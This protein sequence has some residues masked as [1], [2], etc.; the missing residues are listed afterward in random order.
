MPELTMIAIT[1]AAAADVRI[2]QPSIEGLI[3]PAFFSES[4]RREERTAKNTRMTYRFMIPCSDC[5]I[6]RYRC[7]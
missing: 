6:R 1:I 5:R 4:K 3:F 2:A 7:K